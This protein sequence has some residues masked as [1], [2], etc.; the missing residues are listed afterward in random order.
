MKLKLNLV[1]LYCS[2]IYLLKIHLSLIDL[3]LKE[4]C[5]NQNALC[6]LKHRQQ[7]EEEKLAFEQH[8]KKL[9]TA[10][11][12][13]TRGAAA[14]EPEPTKPESGAGEASSAVAAQ[15]A[16]MV[17]VIAKAADDD[18]IKAVMNLTT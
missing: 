15:G 3:F 13:G 16:A 12:R 17:V 9:L 2:A 1:F 10:P 5:I 11:K 8:S 7:L 4:F 6:R 18:A 14:P